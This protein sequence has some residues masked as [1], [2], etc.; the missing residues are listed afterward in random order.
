MMR[1]QGF[2]LVVGVPS[3]DIPVTSKLRGLYERIYSPMTGCGA[4]ITV[5]TRG[6]GNAQCVRVM[7][8]VVSM[9]EDVRY[10][11]TTNHIALLEVNASVRPPHV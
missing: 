7:K 8:W 11:G 2:T 4:A 9:V 6:S 3:A 1:P 10:I 5:Q